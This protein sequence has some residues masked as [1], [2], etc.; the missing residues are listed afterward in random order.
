MAVARA[1]EF[2]VYVGISDRAYPGEYHGFKSSSVAG[3]ADPWPRNGT[4]FFA[5]IGDRSLAAYV[6]DLAR[7]RELRQYRN[8]HAFLSDETFVG[9]VLQARGHSLHTKHR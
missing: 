4:G 6:I 3:L 2:S 1:Y 8:E 5:R 9:G 7:L